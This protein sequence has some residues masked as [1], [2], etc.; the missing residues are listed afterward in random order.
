MAGATKMGS[1]DGGVIVELL[2]FQHAELS[3]LLQQQL[4]QVE[5]P[6]RAGRAALIQDATGQTVVRLVGS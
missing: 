2:R 4:L 6:R 1:V 5:A 3:R